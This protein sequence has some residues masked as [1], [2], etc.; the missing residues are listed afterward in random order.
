M[1]SPNNVNILLLDGDLP[2][3]SPNIGSA[4]HFKAIGESVVKGLDSPVH[5]VLQDPAV[6][7]RVAA[8]EGVRFDQAYREIANAMPPSGPTTGKALLIVMLDMKAELQEQFEAGY[9]GHL[10]SRTRLPGFLS[11]RLFKST[12]GGSPE[13]LALYEL[14]DPAGPTSPEYLSQLPDPTSAM[15][16]D[17]GHLLVRQVYVEVSN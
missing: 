14:S 16:R 7:G 6:D 11:A 5:L 2:P 4:R 1:P 17:H 12:N 3:A 8:G 15:L 10:G 13:Y 9:G